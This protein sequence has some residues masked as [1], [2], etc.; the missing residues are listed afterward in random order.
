MSKQPGWREQETNPLSPASL[1]PGDGSA[2]L[3]LGP[4][5]MGDFAGGAPKWGSD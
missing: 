1:L 2:A 5:E 3:D 4:A